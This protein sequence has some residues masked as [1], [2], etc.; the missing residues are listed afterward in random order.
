M[1]ASFSVSLNQGVNPGSCVNVDF[2]IGFD[3]I[4]PDQSWNNT[5]NLNSYWSLPASS[6][7]LYAPMGPVLFGMN[8]A[9]PLTPPSKTLLLSTG[10]VSGEVTIGDE[11]VYRIAV[12][13]TALLGTLYDVRIQ[14]TLN[15]ALEFVSASNGVVAIANSGTPS[16]VILNLGTLSAQAVVDLRVRVANNAAAVAG[17]LLDNT[18]SYTYALSLGGVP[19]NGGS[20]TT[21]PAERQKIVEPR[22][23]LAKS[24]ANVTAPGVAPKAGDVLRYTLTLNASGG[25]AADNFSNAYDVSVLDT[26]SLGLAYQ[27]NPTV[28]G[29]AIRSWRRRW[30][31]ATAS[32]RRR[33]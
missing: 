23:G 28:T 25:V 29:P 18:A 13:G 2:N 3:A 27:G 24:V 16:N 30:S 17:T 5:L 21:L 31:A 11:L 1:P 10:S 32:R 26:L 33:C 14:D 4:A 8:N 9:A 7:Q 12:P 20:A 6:G 22:L 15:P 19:I